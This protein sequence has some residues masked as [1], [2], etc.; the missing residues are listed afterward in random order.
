MPGEFI[1]LAEDTGL[2]VPIGEWVLRQ[3]CLQSSRWQERGIAPVRLAV[4]IS[5]R[6]FRQAGFL[7][8]VLDALRNSGLPP[9][10][11]SLKLPKPP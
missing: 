4:N 9:N 2:I 3:A 8:M 6:Q 1:P 10:G 5:A 7:E 11:W